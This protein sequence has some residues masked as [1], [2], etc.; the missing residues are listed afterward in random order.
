MTDR[1]D[2]V[3]DGISAGQVEAGSLV[4]ESIVKSRVVSFWNFSLDPFHWG[5]RL[6]PGCELLLW[7]A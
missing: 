6:V 1:K 7:R 4:S 2:K 3:H 5:S